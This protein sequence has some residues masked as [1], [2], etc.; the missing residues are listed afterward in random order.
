MD[1]NKSPE[2]M[3]D[4]VVLEIQELGINIQNSLGGIKS[5]LFTILIL[6]AVALYHF[7]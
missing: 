2:D 3:A 6:G 5:L 1:D 4:E 7:W